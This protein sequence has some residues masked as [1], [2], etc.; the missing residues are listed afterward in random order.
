MINPDLKEHILKSPN[1]ALTLAEYMHG[2]IQ[3]YALGMI[4]K[5]LESIEHKLEENWLLKE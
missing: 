1:P 2:Y 3:G 4:F 5:K